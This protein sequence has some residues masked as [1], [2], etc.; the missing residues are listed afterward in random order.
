MGAFFDNLHVFKND[1]YDLDKLQNE[2]SNI[3][4]NR[5]FSLLPEGSEGDVSLMI[6]EPD[7]SSWVSIASDAFM[8]DSEAAIRSY[9]DPIS[10]AFST[11]VIAATCYDSDYLRLA[12]L[13]SVDNT[14]GWINVGKSYDPLI[15]RTKVAP[16]KKL[17]KNIDEL[18]TVIK[19]YHAC[20]EE[21][22]SEIAD[23]IGMQSQQTILG[24]GG[25]EL[26]TGK[27]T[28]MAFSAPEGEIK[29]P[30]FEVHGYSMPASKEAMLGGDISVSFLN[31]GGKAKGLQLIFCGDCV[32]ND[33]IIFEDV[34]LYYDDKHHPIELQKAKL[35]G[36]GECYS[37][38]D[39]H[40]Q[41]PP[42]VNEKLPLTKKM[43]LEFDRHIAV[44]FT[45]KG[46]LDHFK[47]L[48][49]VGIPLSNPTEGQ[50]CW[51]DYSEY[52]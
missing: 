13:N 52:C 37:W 10:Q 12:L 18:K 38:E 4:K 39:P 27:I 36:G 46:N 41:L 16:W 40:F 15:R 3:L 5:G 32:D 30:K 14:D 25:E 19:N 24:C 43:Q 48:R 28:K 23:M 31:T 44:H 42:A 17:V 22:F 26:L 21:V 34:S 8:F 51:Y 45:L 1:K 33:E 20:A 49:I 29:P 7:D 47:T 50:A 11:D 6:F 9:T 35:V 2:L